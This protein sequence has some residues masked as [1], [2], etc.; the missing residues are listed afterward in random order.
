[1]NHMILPCFQLVGGVQRIDESIDTT[2]NPFHAFLIFF[3]II[4]SNQKNKSENKKTLLLTWT[5]M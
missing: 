1:M 4:G 2:S 3:T 5:M